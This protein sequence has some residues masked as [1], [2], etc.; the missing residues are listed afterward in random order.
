MSSYL[1]AIEES[2]DNDARMRIDAARYVAWRSLALVFKPEGDPFCDA[3]M[4]A[5]TEADIDAAIDAAMA[6]RG[7]A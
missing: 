1:L 2:R 7:K 3:M 4:A 5:R 6:A